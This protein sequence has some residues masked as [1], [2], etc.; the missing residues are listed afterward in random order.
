[1]NVTLWEEFL[2]SD[3][4]DYLGTGWSEDQLSDPRWVGGFL[5]RWNLSAPNLDRARLLDAL[6][7]L[8]QTLQRS[9][10]RV[11]AGRRLRA[12]DLA[13]LGAYLKASPFTRTIELRRGKP[14]VGFEPVERTISAVL[15]EIAFSFAETLAAGELARVRICG[16]AD[17]R[18][19]FYDRSKNR[20]R[21]WCGPT[22]GN[23]MKVRRFRRRRR[24]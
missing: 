3:R 8:R 19:I 2:N 1:M 12:S 6:R 9:A 16:N 5:K 13:E 24:S 22:C 10:E 7:P 14:R 4:H 17:C 23:L 18:W 20:G 11:A 21:K 15:A